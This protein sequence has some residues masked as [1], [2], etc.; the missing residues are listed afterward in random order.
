MPRDDQVEAV[1]Q[2]LLPKLLPRE[3]SITA[4]EELEI[5]KRKAIDQGYPES[6]LKKIASSKGGTSKSGTGK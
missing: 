4:D 3:G 1:K 2:F 5:R 6:P